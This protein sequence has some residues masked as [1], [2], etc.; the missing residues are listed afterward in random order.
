MN[1]WV[2]A[3]EVIERSAM[4]YTPAGVP[5]LDLKLKAESTVTED[6]RPRK[7]SLEVRAVAIGA[8][9]RSVNALVLGEPVQCAGFLTT[10]RNGKGLVYHLTELA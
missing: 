10:S 9:T 4:R 6:G 1:R 5:A 8:I 7:V 3:A 2:L